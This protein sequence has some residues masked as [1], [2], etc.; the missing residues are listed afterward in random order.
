MNEKSIAFLVHFEV[1]F[2]FLK[3]NKKLKKNTL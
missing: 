2:S 1:R 3:M